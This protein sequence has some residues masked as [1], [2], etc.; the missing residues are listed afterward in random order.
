MPLWLAAAA[1]SLG[2]QSNLLGKEDPRSKT[3][4]QESILASP[5]IPQTQRRSWSTSVKCWW[6]K[7]PLITPRTQAAL[8]RPTSHRCPVFPS[9][10]STCTPTIPPGPGRSPTLVHYRV[11]AFNQ[12]LLPW[13]ENS[14][15]MTAKIREGKEKQ[16]YWLQSIKQN[17][18]LLGFSTAR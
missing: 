4:C 8:C 5:A 14:K 11:V 9:I 12:F 10:R 1:V 16:I 17:K 3:L 7:L 2:R 15:F 18:F 6:W 13:S